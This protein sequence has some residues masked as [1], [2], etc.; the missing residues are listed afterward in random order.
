[1]GDRRT[2]ADGKPRRDQDVAEQSRFDVDE[3]Q[4]AD[5]S[6]G[7]L[8]EL[9][10]NGG[11]GE[12]FRN[13]FY[14]P[15]KSYT[16]RQFL[17]SFYSQFDPRVCTGR[18][19][20]TA[21]F[22]ALGEKVLKTLGGLRDGVLARVDIERLY[23]EFRCRFWMGKN[24]SVNNRLGPSL[25]PFIDG[26]VVPDALHLPLSSK[27]FGRFE[28][29]MIREISPSLASYDTVYGHSFASDPS[30][31]HVV[32]DL[33]TFVRPP[34]LRR[35]MFRLHQRRNPPPRPYW[36]KDDYLGRVIDLGFP[37]LGN[38]F[39]LSEVR[40]NDQYNRICTL[41]YLCQRYNPDLQAAA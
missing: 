14:L 39:N 17:W 2:S 23:P 1:M 21:Y 4:D 30:L 27:N 13:F 19:N 38:L 5:D 18:F 8:G 40:S 31:K 26:N 9:M 36:L 28:A 32:K 20:E 35:Y 11:G 3:R 25:T 10:L 24:N 37:F 34:A 22:R 12:I 33:A 41:E 15:N 29:R 7:R 16:V 6:A